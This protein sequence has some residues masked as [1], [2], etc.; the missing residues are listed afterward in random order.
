M[1]STRLGI[2]YA[3]AGAAILWL[4]GPAFIRLWAGPGVL[5]DRATYALQVA[6]FALTVWVSPAATVLW[7]TTRHY[8]WAAITMFEGVLN[9]VLSLWAVRHFGLAGVIGGTIV[10]SV[11]TNF[12]YIPASAASMLH[13]APRRAA[14]E[15]LPGLAVAAA[16]IAALFALSPA[17]GTQP[18]AAIIAAAVGLPIFTTAYARVGFTRREREVFLGWLARYLPA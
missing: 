5:P 6:F 7:A 2:F 3:A 16:A 11:L 10:A 14:A 17:Y 1:L 9:L 4:I 18:G 12:W 8:R 13:I 15:I